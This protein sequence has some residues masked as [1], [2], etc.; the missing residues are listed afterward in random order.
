MTDKIHEFLGRK[1]KEV[2]DCSHDK[3]NCIHLFDMSVMEVKYFIEVEEPKFPK[4]FDEHFT[5][6]FKIIV[7]EN[8]LIIDKNHSD[9][10]FIGKPDGRR[11]KILKDAIEY[12]EE[13]W[14]NDR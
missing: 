4:V 11:F 13:N 6:G 10:I 12:T 5:D 8:G 3:R 9:S 14:K 7:E 2:S 1:W